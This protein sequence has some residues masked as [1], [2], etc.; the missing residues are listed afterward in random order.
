MS[1]SPQ[2]LDELRS[3]IT[4][5]GVIGR[6]VKLMKAGR[7]FKA[8]CPFHNEK[9]PSFYVNDDKGFYHCFGCS[10]HGD[11]IR[12]LT[13]AKGLPFMDAVKELAQAAGI[14]VPAS[15]PRSAQ[16]QEIQATLYDVTAGAARW[17]EEQLSGIEGA[18]ARTYV[19]KRGLD[20]KLV[21][22]FGIGFA[23]DSRGKLKMALATHGHDKLIET[24]L[25]IQ[26]DDKEPYD[27][28][29]GRLIIPIRDQRG[30][31]IAFGGRIIG[32]G[33]PKYLNSPETPLFDKGRTLF[34]IDRAAPASRKSG[35]AIVVEG[36]MDVIALAKAGIDEAVAPLGTALT[37]QQMEKLWRLV[38]APILCFDGDKAGQKA[39]V[40]AG[41][42]ALPVLTVGKTLRFAM[43]PPGKDPDD[44]VGEGGSAAIEPFL[45][46]PSP[47][48]RVLYNSRLSEID[49]SNP[50][51]RAGLRHR[52]DDLAKS[53]TDKILQEEYRRSFTSLFFE[54]FGWKGRDRTVVGDAISRTRRDIKTYQSIAR[55][56]LYGCFRFP[57][58]LL[59][60]LEDI[61]KIDF[62]DD[63]L[64][65]WREKIVDSVS[66]RPFLR[67]DGVIAILEADMISPPQKFDITRDLRFS[68]NVSPEVGTARLTRI[69]RFLVENE[70]LSKAL[71]ELNHRVINDTGMG[72]Y[73]ALEKMRADV[74]AKIKVIRD[75]EYESGATD[76]EADKEEL[77]GAAGQSAASATA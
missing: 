70:A 4:L 22:A 3:R 17:F 37:E 36:Y 14:E 47:L 64:K 18:E 33:E 67:D 69:I 63:V 40:R 77:G 38:D 52:L 74:R 75:Q 68:L 12:F 28:F 1:L 34:N 61:C 56:A 30:R 15:D 8:C 57:Q 65:I 7:E 46:A 19:K 51:D 48:V 13:E 50:E 59:R 5:S 43:L 32:D 29:R 71:D 54:D 10:A 24:G 73:V 20:D 31:V 62:D 27:R 41:E 26:V 35:R 76:A 72:N 39:A 58:T 6:S 45:A 11:A 55:S 66:A 25:L 49:R 21:R 60:S 16:R 9:S 42:R 2:F 44:I 53:C 23:P